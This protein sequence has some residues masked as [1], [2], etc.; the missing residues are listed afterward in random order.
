MADTIT[1]ENLTS[2][3]LLRQFL[4]QLK[5]R[6]SLQPDNVR[7]LWQIAQTFRALGEFEQALHYYNSCLNFEPDHQEARYFTA[8]LSGKDNS[9]PLN[10]CKSLAPPFLR[11]ENFLS[12]EALAVLWQ[13]TEDLLSRLNPSVVSQNN[14]IGL[15]Q[16]L[17]RSLST[18]AD[19][20]IRAIFH[21][22]VE[23]TVK[24]YNIIKRLGIPNLTSMQSLQMSLIAYGNGD[25]F[26][27]HRDVGKTTTN[28][29][30]RELTFVY[31]FFRIPKRFSGGE[32][33][34]YD[35]GLDDEECCQS[36]NLTRFEPIHN[37]ILFFPSKALHEVR[38]I[39]CESNDPLDGRFAVTG[40]A[41]RS[42][43]T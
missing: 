14:W 30:L 19:P 5:A 37:S 38:H 16:E 39:Q 27:P 28:N 1:K 18:N 12:D 43:E 23:D 41:L 7:L 42:E 33:H 22:L 36:N 29:R 4:V 3:L 35:A 26:K 13:A 8:L 20:R 24:Q 11:F 25:Y 2:P 15:N 32:L 40:W 31:H 21:D 6:V 9:V 34:L 17:R 10:F